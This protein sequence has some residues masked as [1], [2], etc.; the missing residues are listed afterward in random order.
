MDIIIFKQKRKDKPAYCT[1]YRNS[2]KKPTFL[3][4]AVIP[5]VIVPPSVSFCVFPKYNFIYKNK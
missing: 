2:N 3:V 1:Y 4:V 5:V